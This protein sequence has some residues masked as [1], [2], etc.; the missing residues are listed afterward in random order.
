MSLS[1]WFQG[2]IMNDFDTVNKLLAQYK[3]S[4]DVQGDT[5]LMVATQ[6]G[7]LGMVRLLAPFESGSRSSSGCTALMIACMSNMP[8]IVEVLLPLE[9]DFRLSDGRDALM[10]AA[11]SNSGDVL[12]ILMP[13]FSLCRDNN[14]LSAL[15]YAGYEGHLFIVMKLVHYFHPSSADLSIARD[16]A[17][18]AGRNAVVA[19]LDSL[20]VNGSPNPVQDASSGGFTNESDILV[21][22]KDSMVVTTSTT[23]EDRISLPHPDDP[24]ALDIA[25]ISP[26]A[27]K[28][29]A[30]LES[31]NKAL[32]LKLEAMTA[33]T[34]EERLLAFSKMENEIAFYMGEVEMLQNS[35]KEKD[36]ADSAN[37]E[38]E[39]IESLQQLLIS[40]KE[41]LDKAREDLSTSLESQSE[42]TGLLLIKEEEG[43][44]L[45][46]EIDSLKRELKT[47]REEL[48]KTELELQNTKHRLKVCEGEVV[49][50]KQL[51][52]TL[53][54]TKSLYGHDL[55]EQL[56][57]PLRNVIPTD[58]DL[59]FIKGTAAQFKANPSELRHLISNFNILKKA[60]VSLLRDCD[61][62]E[63]SPQRSTTGVCK[64]HGSLRNKS[65]RA[66]DSMDTLI[67]S[68]NT[69]IRRSSSRTAPLSRSSSSQIIQIV[70]NQGTDIER[71]QSS[72]A[73]NR[74]RSIV[75]G[76]Q[77]G[78]SVTARDRA[79]DVSLMTEDMMAELS[80]SENTPLMKAFVEGNLDGVLNMLSH[81]GRQRSDGTT[82]LMLAALFNRISAIKYVVKKEARMK[83]VDGATALHIALQKGYYTIADL[84]TKYEGIDVSEYST[85]GN[86]KTELMCAAEENDLVKLWC[87]RPLQER[88]QDQNGKTA[89]MYAL[90]KGNLHCVYL[91]LSSEAKIR[92]NQGN[93]IVSYCSKMSHALPESLRQELTFMATRYCN[94]QYYMD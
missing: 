19:Y 5:G 61:K 13:N 21:D 6:A 65:A 1:D 36:L 27:E 15:D 33:S 86:R 66:R 53:V 14:S 37:I 38:S 55:R 72:L 80:N 89:L 39:S 93:N 68:I 10:L 85:E 92:D 28:R 8:E 31:E 82:A 26:P 67:T 32:R 16:L 90:E 81:V 23:G 41:E 42:L 91:L 76:T 29:I 94:E 64:G 3:C 20:D 60:Y 83:R 88:L 63:S 70:S 62:V 25:T 34:D 56:A 22:R 30:F 69:S 7:L 46:A 49:I 71:A 77:I 54:L 50:G 44:K 84:L 48:E 78:R 9:K 11:S 75:S 24:F 17:S 51:D 12:D 47:S 58:I 43:K 2:I 45:S 73:D 74:Q 18:E 59:R 4:V 57:V 40:A 35:L 52:N 87:L 79:T